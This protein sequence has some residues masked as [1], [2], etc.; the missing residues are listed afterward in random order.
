L[1]SFNFLGGWIVTKRMNTL[2]ALAGLSVLSATGLLL[3]QAPPTPAPK[4]FPG[5]ITPHS[6]TQ[7]VY[8]G[9]P[10]P[11]RAAAP[12][13]PPER[14]VVKSYDP[15][16]G[17]EK[18]KPMVDPAVKPVQAIEIPLP[19]PGIPSAPGELVPLPPI[20][21]EMKPGAAPSITAERVAP[22]PFNVPS[23]TSIPDKPSPAPT[24]S[25]SLMANIP[26]T[27][28]LSAKQSPTVSVEYEM[29]ESVGVGQTLIYHLVVKNLGSSAISGVR[30]E[31]ETPTGSQFISSEPAA[32]T[33]AD[34]RLS[35]L[36]GSME[37]GA[38]KKIKVSV[39][40]SDE[41]EIRGRATVSFVSA[42]EA[43]VKVTRPK[44]NIALTAIESARVGDKVTVSIKLTNTGSGPA[45]S[46]T[47]QARLT[48]GL[49]HAAGAVIEAPLSNL[50]AGAS[51]TRNLEVTAAKS[52]QQQVTL[53][54]FAD[55][56]PA[57]TSKV[58]INLVEPQLTAKQTG[59]SKCYVKAEPTYTI[60]LGNPGT[61]TNDPISMWTM[62]PEG[63][64]FVSATEGGTY[65]ATHKAVVWK[66]SGLNAGANKSISVKL[67]SV[68]PTEGTIRTLVQS[69]APEATTKDTVTPA[70][71]KARML[72]AKCETAIKAEGVPALR[73]EVM[74]V[75]DPVEVGKEALYEIKVT[76]QGTGP[77]T[78][79]AI[80]AELAEGTVAGATSGPTNAK[81]SGNT[82]VFET[83]AT[84]PVKGEAV[85]KVRVKGTTAGDCRF[86]VK[87]TSD[88]IKTPIVK[89][90][91]TRFYKD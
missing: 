85:Y 31:Q 6:S 17:N 40:P 4:F 75:D 5:T 12:G 24:P 80:V 84:L 81:P 91:N 88:Q 79:V 82:I 68:A 36:V 39:K 13:S 9:A 44:I 35:W 86:R 30:V 58:N 2:A 37:A 83:L 71:G 72:E 46:M 22:A 64:E 60:E 47:L 16:N 67:R 89:E 21:T 20:G 54:V 15:A 29:P 28:N 33:N 19:K 62:L 74:D 11:V 50:A 48:D 55:S 66:L 70:S 10:A 1:N 7:G 45:N 63:F 41:G 25:P 3:A 77:C 78:N 38:E 51:I 18:T 69:G 65:S 76:N 49:T 26:S 52:G 90:E 61:T 23:I 34:A 42:V 87:L 73:F 8:N 27:G 53:A 56:N 32:E 14:P 43:K 59:P 57:E